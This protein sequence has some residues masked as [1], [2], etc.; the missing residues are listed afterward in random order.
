MH[1]TLRRVV[2]C[3]T[4]V[5]ASCALVLHSLNEILVAT[6]YASR[7]LP[8]VLC[9]GSSPPAAR[10]STT[11]DLELVMPRYSAQMVLR[12]SWCSSSSETGTRRHQ[13][14]RCGAEESRIARRAPSLGHLGESSSIRFDRIYP[15]T[16]RCTGALVLYREARLQ[17]HM[18]AAA[19]RR[20]PV[21]CSHLLRAAAQPVRSG[22]LRSSCAFHSA[23]RALDGRCTAAECQLC[24]RS[25]VPCVAAARQHCAPAQAD[26]GQATRHSAS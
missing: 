19:V 2:P 14:S 24:C 23:T 13:A 7:I 12:T 15:N 11:A 22:P 1:R 5:G 6:S 21:L 3:E 10:R 20:R 17:D 8:C 26:L 4:A 9:A 16:T 18:A 25:C